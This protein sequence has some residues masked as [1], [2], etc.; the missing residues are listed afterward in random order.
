M[1][2]LARCSDQL[3]E[4]VMSPVLMTQGLSANVELR[5]LQ[6][7]LQLYKTANERYLPA[8]EFEAWVGREFRGNLKDPALDAWGQKYR[9][10]VFGGGFGLRSAGPDRRLKTP[11]DIVLLWKEKQ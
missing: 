7:S 10:W 1:V 11:D 2:L 9:Y 3:K 6:Y 5:N 8:S 4:V